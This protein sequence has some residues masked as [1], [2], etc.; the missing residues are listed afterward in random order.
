MW[1]RLLALS[2][3]ALPA[4]SPAAPA[5]LPRVELLTSAGRLVLEVDTRHAPITAGNFLT[6]V[7]EHRLDNTTFYRAAPAKT[8]HTR[9]FIQGG[10]NHDVSRQRWPI[11]HE[12]TTLTHLT[13]DD[14]ALSMARNEPGTAAGD[15]S[16]VVKDARYLDARPGYPGYAAFGH[17]V[18]GMDIVRR[19]MVQP[20]WPGGR[21][22]E[23]LGQMLRQPVRIIA[24]R[25]LR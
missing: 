24:A 6:Y 7:D 15:F 12:P 16:I 23:T 21:S 25:R 22:K 11:E 10:L 2:L 13:H 3:L 20:T 14:G 1:R 4:P 9:G 8:D 19:I 5:P 18:S 17:V